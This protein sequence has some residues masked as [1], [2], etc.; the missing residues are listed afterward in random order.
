MPEDWPERIAVSVFDLDG[1]GML[2]EATRLACHDMAAWAW[3]EVRTALAESQRL[4]DEERRAR[5]FQ[6]E[7]RKQAEATVARLTGELETARQ[8][9]RV[10][11]ARF[12]VAESRADRAYAVQHAAEAT[13]TALQS[14]L[15]EYAD[16]LMLEY[17]GGH[18]A[19]DESK[20][21]RRLAE[22]TLSPSDTGSQG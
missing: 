8:T 13:L 21:V 11:E 17:D 19:T 20:R 18:L 1:L 9:A 5:D 14:K 22:F 6:W 2:E 15:H 3:R 4:L 12:E 7:L 10:W 16:S